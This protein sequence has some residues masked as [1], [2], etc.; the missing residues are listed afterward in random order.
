[1]MQRIMLIVALNIFLVSM[2]A[3]CGNDRS[4]QPVYPAQ[5]NRFTL[6]S[7]IPLD[8]AAH[9]PPSGKVIF[10]FNRQIDEKSLRNAVA[11]VRVFEDGSTA[12]IP[13]SISA[14]GK[15]IYVNPKEPLWSSSK[16]RVTLAD[17]IRCVSGE[18]Y[19]NDENRRT[20]EFRTGQ[21][22]AL[23]T[24]K[25]EVV[26]TKPD[27]SDDFIADTST[28]RVYFSEPLSESATKY[29]GHIKLL[30]DGTENVPAMM[31]VYGDTVVI[32][33]DIDL[34]AQTDYTLSITGVTDRN[35]ERMEGTYQ[36]DF[37]VTATYIQEKSDSESNTNSR[38]NTI[39]MTLCPTLGDYSSDDCAVSADPAT[40]PPS[41][42]TGDLSNTAV[43]NSKLLGYNTIYVSGE[44]N[45]EV[46]D[47]TIDPD[48]LPIVIRKGQK[49]Y[50]K[51][52]ETKIGGQIQTGHETGDIAFTLVSDASGMIAGSKLV[53]GIENKPAAFIIS[54]DLAVNTES[55]FPSTNSMFTQ[56]LLGIDFL[57]KTT[58]RN[59]KMKMQ[60]TG[61]TE[62]KIQGETIPL[63]LNFSL[64]SS[65]RAVSEEKADTTPPRLRITTPALNDRRVPLT[66]QVVAYYDEP[67]DP[68]S[69]RQFFFVQS[70]AGAEISGVVKT[71]GSKIVFT[72]NEY[73][74]PNTDYKIIVEPGIADISR[75]A[76]TKTEDYSF[77]TG[78]DEASDSLDF[79]PL[80]TTTQPGPYENADLP[81]NFPLVVCFNQAMD[82]NTIRLGDSFNVYDMNDGFT[83]V[84]G[85]IY[86]QGSYF[87][88]E[89]NENWVP[90][91]LYRMVIT[92]DMTNL[93]GVPVSFK[94]FDTDGLQEVSIDFRTTNRSEWVMLHMMLD[95]IVDT[96][97]S[98]FVDGN[99]TGNEDNKWKMH[100]FIFE[101]FSYPAGHLIFWLK[102]ILYDDFGVPYMATDMMDGTFF[103]STS[104]RVEIF[105]KKESEKGL[106]DPMG[107]TFFDQLQ[108]NPANIV[109]AS[110]QRAKMNMQMSMKFNMENE[111]FDEMIDNF[112]EFK[113]KGMLS[114]SKDG[115]IVSEISGSFYVRGAFDI[116]LIGWDLPL[117]IPT[118]LKWRAIT[119]PLPYN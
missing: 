87:I 25:P 33:P 49:L 68:E 93:Y 30:K 82:L 8:Q 3:G 19:V 50:G 70:D 59:N 109:Q 58:V 51:S 13:V 81:A 105:S 52:I 114:F 6:M 83:S 20:I 91:H 116:P 41:P 106:F 71:L 117:V 46:G 74:S 113:P 85:T 86:H 2:L 17:E 18:S 1:M 56:P 12:D 43:F 111:T 24:I 79:P 69:I 31:F 15:N 102:G 26:A 110:S 66:R 78:A 45:I 112:I 32:D 57:G 35:G 72:P 23:A 77:R 88:F 89:P 39:P 65:N 42:Y 48:F 103:T 60:F 115:R 61:F 11:F 34:D 22:R 96:N 95:P 10:H 84:R 99:E 94:T 76:T 9:V 119:T 80:L 44:L 54:M 62:M 47:S 108:V 98:G 67:V 7:T 38:R 90:G 107:M 101:D 97:G 36:R 100:F 73:F 21:S 16:F 75:N 27:L 63:V 104:V 40:L 64:F 29:G 55:S 4:N 53:F 5:D 118:T 28:F 37:Q 14:V 92:N